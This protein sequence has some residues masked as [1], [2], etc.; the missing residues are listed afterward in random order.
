MVEN[1]H[2]HPWVRNGLR[3]TAA[4]LIAWNLSD[5]QSTGLDMSRLPAG[6]DVANDICTLHETP[7]L[8]PKPEV[9]NNLLTMPRRRQVI[10]APSQAAYAQMYLN[11][12]D[13]P[14]EVIQPVL[15]GDI[16]AIKQME[17]KA[18]DI[19][20]YHPDEQAVV[21]NPY[22]LLMVPVGFSPE[23]IAG[24]FPGMEDTMT[25]VTDG[26]PLEFAHLRYS[27]PIGIQHIGVTT[28]FT[29]PKEIAAAR[30]KI[31]KEYPA[32]RVMVVVNSTEYLGTNLY[33][34]WES[35]GDPVM[36]EQYAIMSTTITNKKDKSY[37]SIHEGIG[38]GAGNLSDGYIR[39]YNLEALIGGTELFVAPNA[40]T[41]AAAGVARPVIEQTKYNCKGYPVFEYTPGSENIMRSPAWTD[42]QLA[43]R[44]K[45]KQVIFDPYQQELMRRHIK[46]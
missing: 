11:G 12:E 33:V 32:D 15:R 19:A 29:D 30:R 7:Q 6:V 8:G 3:I 27:V 9:A 42:E 25:Q 21:A 39:Q 31:R 28:K 4:G 20:V 26:F 5:S 2:F 46:K 45:N 18:E 41:Y 36:G 13:V 35:P 14:A 37:L 17:V 34:P 10:E 23:E 24:L 40:D 1:K 43:S 44:I 38:H 22:R 16:A